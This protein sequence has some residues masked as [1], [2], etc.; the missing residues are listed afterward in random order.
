MPPFIRRNPN[1]IDPVPQQLFQGNPDLAAFLNPNGQGQQPPAP[2]GPVPPP[3]FWQNMG[4]QGQLAGGVP[5]L[6]NTPDDARQN[7]R[8]INLMSNASNAANS[9]VGPANAAGPATQPSPTP[10]W[11]NSIP[12]PTGTQGM[13]FPQGLPDQLR[14]NGPV[15]HQGGNVN[16]MPGSMVPWTPGSAIPQGAQL[17]RDADTGGYRLGDLNPGQMAD[18][19]NVTGAHSPE[20]MLRQQMLNGSHGGL[21]MTPEQ[22]VAFQSLGASA[23]ANN[24][25]P[26]I[27]PVIQTTGRH[28]EVSM[29]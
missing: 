23:N 14:W 18:P 25:M 15:A 1:E 12:A 10:A 3:Q 8:S 24:Q 16:W 19:F 9:A 26:S 28:R 20:Q 11:N 21:S 7:V 13:A 17:Y 4:S 29:G 5:Q 27:N 6:S 22:R 2:G